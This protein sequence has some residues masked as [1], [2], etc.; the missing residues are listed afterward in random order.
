M[1]YPAELRGRLFFQGLMKVILTFVP[2]HSDFF[3]CFVPQH[4]A[5][6]LDRFNKAGR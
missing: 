5:F 2:F 4:K 1:L 3:P 6:L